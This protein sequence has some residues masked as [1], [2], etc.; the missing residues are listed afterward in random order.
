LGDNL[1]AIELLTKSIIIKEKLLGFDHNQVA[2][3][4]SNLGLYYHTARYF[5][6]GFSCMQRSLNILQ[7]I[8]GYNHP[9]INNIFINLGMMFQDA[10]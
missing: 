3:S 8:T 10:D 1:T 2:Y 9:D 7:N 6:M 4:Y 5:K